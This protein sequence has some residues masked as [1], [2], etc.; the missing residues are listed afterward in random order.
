MNEIETKE[1]LASQHFWYVVFTIVFFGVFAFF[2]RSYGVV[3]TRALLDISLLNL[4]ILILATFRITRLFVAD[5]STQWLRD[6]CLVVTCN[7][8]LATGLSSIVRT[9]RTRG[10]RR[11]FSEILECSWCMGVWVAFL[12]VVLYIMAIEY[13]F[14]AGWFLLVIF[15][16]AGGAAIMNTFLPASPAP[17]PAYKIPERRSSPPNVCTEC[18]A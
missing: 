13:L 4:I 3:A 9:K 2:A 10:I 15:A 6:M 12:V 5:K 17:Q 1:A 8:D 11:V 7:T 16:I 14:V 18:G